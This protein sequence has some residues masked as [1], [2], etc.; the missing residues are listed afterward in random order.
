MWHF[1]HDAASAVRASA[2]CFY[3]HEEETKYNKTY[4]VPIKMH[5]VSFSLKN[6]VR[7]Q[8]AVHLKVK[9]AIFVPFAPSHRIMKIFHRISLSRS[10]I[11]FYD[12][13]ILTA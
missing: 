4:A 7:L 10:R 1:Q 6:H 13:F 2:A 8:H 11:Y 5:I 3:K 12:L 9:C